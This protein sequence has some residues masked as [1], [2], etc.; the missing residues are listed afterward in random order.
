AA[1][2]TPGER[3]ARSGDRQGPEGDLPAVMRA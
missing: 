2:E 1:K 3:A